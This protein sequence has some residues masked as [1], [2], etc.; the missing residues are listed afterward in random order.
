MKISTRHIALV[1][2]FAALYYI[3]SLVSP[4]IPAIGLPDIKI[5]LEAL[6]ASVYG[7]ILGPYLGAFAAFLGA[8]VSWILPPSSV[9]PF[10]APFL[11]SPPINALVVGLIYYR[12]W[13]WAFAVF[14][15]LILVFLLSPPSQPLTGYSQIFDPFSPENAYT[16][17]IYYV[18]AAVLWD[19]VIA[20]F[21]ILPVVKFAKRL[22]SP[23]GLPVLF[24]L[25]TF[26]GNQADNMWGC[27]AF[28]LPIVYEYIFSLPLEAVRFYFLIS[29][30]IYPAIRLAQ[31]IVATIIVVPLVRA[32]KNTEWII[33]EKSIIEE[34]AKEALKKEN[35]AH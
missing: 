17:P 15:V 5:K 9:S 12:K 8:F 22:S 14:G 1:A 33:A 13:R 24:F 6:I 20:L 32:L 31:A 28:A 19:K 16:I 7:I 26:I 29:P 11:L 10:G 3:L 18:P 25:L 30:F 23:K 27:N 35:A 34:N 2:I 21:L 4:Y